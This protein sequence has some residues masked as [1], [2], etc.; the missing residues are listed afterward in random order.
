MKRIVIVFAVLMA[1]ISSIN[2]QLIAFPGA[3]GFGK[4][5]VGGRGGEVVAVTNLDDY[6]S[7]ESE[8]VGSLRWALSQFVTASTADRVY[9]D[10]YGADSIVQKPITIYTPL[11]IV[12]KVS[13]TIWLKEDLKVK[14]DSLTIAGQTAPGDGICI[15]GRSVLFNGATGAEMFHWGPRRTDLI[16][17]HIRFRPGIPKDDTGTP[18]NAF[19]TYGVD[20][21]NYQNVIFDHCSISWANEECLATYDTKNITFQWCMVTE[22]LECAYHPKGLRAYGGVWGGQFASYH[23]NLIA[24]NVSRTARFN[25]ARVHDTIAVIDYRNNVVYNWGSSDGP[26]GGE[27]QI[28]GGRSEINMLNNYYKKGSA[29]SASST[30]SSS[31]KGHRLLYLYDAASPANGTGKHYVNG[32]YT[33]GYPTVIANNWEYGIQFKYYSVADTASTFS[34][35]RL[36]TPSSEVATILP[37]VVDPATTSYNDVLLSAGA[38]LPFRDAQDKRIALEVQN[39][40]VSGSGTVASV[41]KSDG[42]VVANPYYNTTKGIIDD[43]EVVGGWPVLATGIVPLDTDNDG[44]PDLFEVANSLNINDPSDRNTLA[45]ST[46][47]WLE[48]YLNSITANTSFIQAPFNLK[49]SINGSSQLVLNWVDNSDNET[50]FEIQKAIKGTGAFLSVTIVGADVETYTDTEMIDNY[51][52]RI[53]AV[54]LTDTSAFSNTAYFLDAPI[55]LKAT[56]NN[57]SIVLEW[58]DQASSESSVDVFRSIAGENNYS[59]IISLAADVVSYTDDYVSDST[60]YDYRVCAGYGV[61][62]SD[63]SNIAQEQIDFAAPSNLVGNINVDNYPALAW[64]DNSDIEDAYIIERFGFDDF[65]SYSIDTVAENTSAY[66]DSTV[67]I[68]VTYRY[69]VLS[70]KGSA[71][72]V[73]SNYYQVSI[74][75]STVLNSINS[76][77]V[78]PNPVVESVTIEAEQIIQKIDIFSIT[79]AF[80]QSID[81]DCNLINIPMENYTEGVYTLRIVAKD[82]NQTSVK[83]VK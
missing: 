38:T 68:G 50:G 41:T 15:A 3:E 81:V 58:M 32:N 1:V 51:E 82:G 72:S 55:T 16:V 61:W 10:I 46:Y 23:H 4:Y 24:H 69:F 5:A 21:E 62:L 19:V 83:I 33:D 48:E 30:V 71:K 40:T 17:R 44:M 52:Y 9:K 59:R 77:K 67:I 6:K 36:N 34:L 7:S 78:Y 80:I 13:G 54:S 14:R 45:P 31:N 28:P 18:T 42:V 22:G 73:F 56:K 70:L 64:D 11:T 66:I 53:R 35:F 65:T 49:S 75:T 20:M 39:G 27:I 60:A 12:F 76:L 63:S 26:A 79:G 37:T 25:G 29:L 74:P 57:A 2:A 43:P 47:T 8:V